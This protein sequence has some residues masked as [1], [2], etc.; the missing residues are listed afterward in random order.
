M[1]NEKEN[2][3]DSLL[4]PYLQQKSTAIQL[5]RHYHWNASLVVL[6][7]KFKTDIVYLHRKK[8]PCNTAVILKFESMPVVPS[9]QLLGL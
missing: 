1:L 2:Y 4:N 5:D 9:I 3:M 8:K 7:Q 6:A